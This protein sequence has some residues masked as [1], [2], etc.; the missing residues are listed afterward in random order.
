MKE[1]EE[2]I[3]A[4]R[5]ERAL[6]MRIAI[7]DLRVEIRGS[8]LVIL[9][10][11]TEPGAVEDLIEKLTTLKSRKYI[12]DEVVRLPDESVGVDPHALVRAALAPVYGDPALPAPQTTQA[13][14]GTRVEPLARARNW[15]RI[16][17]EDG[18]IGW[19]HDGYLQFGNREWAYAWETASSGEPVVSLGAELLDDAGRVFARLPWGARVTRFSQ[20]QYELPDGR[21][22]LLGSG[23]IVA[24][25]RLADWFP[26][27]GDSVTR[28]ARRWVGAPYLWGGVTTGGVDCSGLVQAVFWLHGIAMPRDSDMQSRRG[29]EID[30]GESYKNLNPGDLLFFSE[31]P[32]RVNHVAI[33]LGGPHIVHSALTNGGVEVND[34]TGDDELEE[35]LRLVFARVMRL[36]PD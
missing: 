20:E 8:K 15:C 12:K 28:T 4:V 32:G 22:G 17:M 23:E 35:K 5:T 33:S 13:V 9:G 3:D 11:T 25:D 1:F 24:V 27:R 10:A 2:Y 36:L 18:Y 30:P 34:M 21:R 31:T 29:E 7:L 14:L 16:R 19:V 26:A 6:D